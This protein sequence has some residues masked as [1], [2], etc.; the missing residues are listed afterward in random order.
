MLWDLVAKEKVMSGDV[1]FDETF[2]LNQNE[3]NT[4]DDGHQQ[5]LVIEWSLVSIR[6]RVIWVMLIP[7]HNNSSSDNK[8]SLYSYKR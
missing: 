6:H 1:S 4:T 7:T 8:M 3:D 5:K 2:M